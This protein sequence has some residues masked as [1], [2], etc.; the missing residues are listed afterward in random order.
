MKDHYS[1][2]FYSGG[3]LPSV[4]HQLCPMVIPDFVDREVRNL[5]NKVCIN[6]LESVY[7][8]E[9]VVSL[10]QRNVAE[11]LVVDCKLISKLF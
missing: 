4:C 2:R 1:F 6:F 7:S 8:F 11:V 9:L 10:L 3:R 5:L